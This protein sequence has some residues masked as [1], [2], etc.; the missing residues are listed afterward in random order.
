VIVPL[1]SSLGN[2]ARPRLYKIKIKHANHCPASTPVQIPAFD[3][4]EAD[5]WGKLRVLEVPL[6]VSGPEREAGRPSQSAGITGVSH[7]AGP[8]PTSFGWQW[9]GYRLFEPQ[10]GRCWDVGPHRSCVVLE[11]ESSW[12]D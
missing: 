1:Q 12:I 7:R 4:R 3:P 2:R 11:V 6:A 8:Q 10:C 5:C 9:F